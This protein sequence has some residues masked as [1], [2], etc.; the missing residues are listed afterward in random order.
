VSSERISVKNEANSMTAALYDK[1]SVPDAPAS[2]K[3]L[4]NGILALVVALAL[5][6]ALIE[7][8]RRVSLN[9]GREK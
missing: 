2:P 1:A 3:P 4:R 7:A 5:S 6:A 8:G 9:E